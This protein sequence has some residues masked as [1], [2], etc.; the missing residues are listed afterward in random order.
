VVVNHFKSKNCDPAPSGGNV[1]SGDGQGCYNAARV[2]QAQALMQFIGQLQAVSPDVAVV[3]DINAY[4]KEDPILALTSAGLVDQIARFNESGYSYVFDG[5]S[6]YL[7]HALT[8]ASLSAKVTGAALWAIN[9]DEPSIIDYNLE[10]KQPACANCGPDYYS[11]TIYRSSDHDPVVLGLSLVKA[12]NGSGN[13]DTL[14]GTAGDDRIDG[15]AGADTLTGGAWS[16]AFVYTSLRDGIDTITDFAPGTD[17]LEL[18][19]LLASLN[20]DPATAIA[21]GVVRLVDTPTGLSVQIDSDGSAGA[22]VP[23]PLVVLQ[24]LTAA[25][26][27]P[28]RDLGL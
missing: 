25:Q 23:R 15:G 20:A 13:R 4:G 19:A 17:R 16:D 28:S 1:D 27:Q 3:G 2:Q 12:I 26:I 18:S 22:G 6:G 7:D 21:Q 9:A 10:F 11:P 5:E 24:G 14:V 8:T